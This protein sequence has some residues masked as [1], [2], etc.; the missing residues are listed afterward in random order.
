M[1]ILYYLWQYLATVVDCNQIVIT[2]CLFN[3]IT[4]CVMC[5]LML[6]PFC[7]SV[8]TERWFRLKG[9]L[10]FYL[11]NR[12]PCSEPQGLIVL[13][14][15]HVEMGPRNQTMFC[16]SLGDITIHWFMVYGYILA[17]QFSLLFDSCK[18]MHNFTD[19]SL[20]VFRQCDL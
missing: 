7:V 11:R 10:L 6:F 18:F 14:Q 2:P 19:V 8:Y 1:L 16:F 13:E 3:N 15:C 4:G 9:N 5:N 20:Q 12:D 17:L